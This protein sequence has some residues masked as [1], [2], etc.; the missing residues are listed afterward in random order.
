MA[1]QKG[2]VLLVTYPYTDFTT[3]KARPAVV[4][5]S[6]CYHAEQPDVV[7]AALT[8]NVPA[9]T[10]SLDYALQDWE[11][12]GLHLPTAFKPVIVTLDPSLIVHRIGHL[13]SRD[14]AEVGVRLHLALD[15]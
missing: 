5:S 6:D 7:L 13:S 1:F 11:A 14:L 2:E 9:A 4:L 15:L 12:A 10:G 8:T 3:I